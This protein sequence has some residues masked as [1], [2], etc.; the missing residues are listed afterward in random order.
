[1]SA[2]QAQSDSM[3]LEGTVLTSYFFHLFTQRCASGTTAA[4][5]P[6]SSWYISS[7]LSKSWAV[8]GEASQYLGIKP[9]RLRHFCFWS[10]NL[11][12]FPLLND[13]NTVQIWLLEKNAQG[14]QK[15]NYLW[16][17]DFCIFWESIVDIVAIAFL[18]TG[19]CDEVQMTKLRAWLQQW[20]KGYNSF[21]LAWTPRYFPLILLAPS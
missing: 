6:I 20:A 4:L 5:G 16:K 13:L 9:Q 21:T 7:N 11:S 19:N 1:M 3:A 14:H 8:F 10:K 18:I 15:D 17:F 12:S 2:W